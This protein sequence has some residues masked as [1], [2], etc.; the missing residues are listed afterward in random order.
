MTEAKPTITIIAGANGSGKSTFTRT[1]RQSLRVPVIDPDLEARLLRPDCPQAAAIEGGRQAIKR[2]RAYLENHESF[3]AETTLSGHTYLR[4]MAEAKQKGWQVNLI[5]VG[6]D[7]VETSIKRVAQRVAEGGHNVPEE[8]IRRRYAR[9]LI[10]LPVALQQ[11]DRALIFDNSTQVGHRQV[12]TIENGIIT[13][14][15]RELPEWIE[16]LLPEFIEEN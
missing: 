10:N 8:D 4:M 12:L 2:A 3:A 16:T 5:Y 1:T 15:A 13:Q 6:I 7:N 11:A 9:S 14:K